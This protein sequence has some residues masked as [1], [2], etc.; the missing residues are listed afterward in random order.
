[1]SDTVGARHAMVDRQIASRGVHDPRVLAAMRKV[2][3][4]AFVPDEMASLAY[5]D[6]PLPIGFDQTISQPFVVG[7][8]SEALGVQE[9]SKVLEIGTGSGYQ[10]AVLGELAREVYTI[11][12]LPELADRA[13]ETLARLGYANVHVRTG[14]GYLGWPEQAPFDA[15]IVTA[16][17]DH[18]PQPLVDQLAIG[19]RLVIPVGDVDQ[20]MRIL[21][22]TTEG[23][24]ETRTL[25][26]RFV[27]LRRGEPPR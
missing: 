22:R 25:P 2:P 10:A 5:A 12:L 23:I 14:D 20:Q 19:G 7:Y 6:Q 3:R 15:I 8:M 27:P 1:M 26:V 9:T 4:E 16:A 17:P 21:T 24:Q 13:R 11:E 18:V